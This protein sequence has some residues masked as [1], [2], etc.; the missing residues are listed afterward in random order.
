[1]NSHPSNSGSLLDTFKAYVN[2]AMTK[3]QEAIE[4][5]NVLGYKAQEQLNQAMAQAQETTHNA[6]TTGKQPNAAN[7]HNQQSSSTTTGAHAQAAYAPM[8]NQD[9]FDDLNK[10]N[11]QATTDNAAFQAHQAQ[12]AAANAASKAS[13]SAI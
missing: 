11:T 1:M 9:A 4:Q 7:S 5:A 2:I 12:Q 10:F 13:Q 3:G 8:S 6:A